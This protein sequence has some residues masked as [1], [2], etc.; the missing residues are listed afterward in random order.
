M[1]T[2]R[3]RGD[4]IT[5]GD[6]LTLSFGGSPASI[7][8]V[9]GEIAFLSGSTEHVRIDS[10]GRVGI[11]IDNPTEKVDVAG[12]VRV[13][14]TSPRVKFLETDISL[15]TWQLGLGGGNFLLYD[16]LEATIP[17]RVNQGAPENSLAILSNGNVGV[18]DSTPEEKLDVLGNIRAQ[19]NLVI[20]R[21]V[22]AD[23]WQPTGHLHLPYGYLGSN[24]SFNVDLLANGYRNNSGTWTSLGINGSDAAAGISIGTTTGDISFKGD[25]SKPSGSSQDPT[26]RMIIKGDGNVGIGIASP[27]EKLHVSGTGLFTST[28]TANGIVSSGN[29]IQMTDVSSKSKIRVWND[30]VF[31]IGMTSGLSFGGIGGDSATDYAMTFQMSNAPNRGFW[32]GDI[33][34]TNAQGAMA[35]TT[36]GKLTV[37]DSIRVGYGQ[38]DTTVPG[39]TYELDVNGTIK[40]TGITLS[41]ISGNTSGI[42]SSGGNGS[43]VYIDS[44]SAV[45]FRE[46]DGNADKITVNVNDTRLGIGV[47]PTEALHV[48]GNGLFTGTVTAPTFSGNLTGNASTA[49]LAGN[50]TGT[51]A[52][53]NGGTGQTSKTAAFDALSPLTTK[54]D[55]IVRNGSNNVRLPVGTNNYVLAADSTTANGVAWKSAASID[56][57]VNPL[58]TAGDIIYSSSGDNPERLPIGSLGQSLGVV[59]KDPASSSFT[60]TDLAFDST[61]ISSSSYQFAYSDNGNTFVDC[62][63]GNFPG[64]SLRLFTRGSGGSFPVVA[65]DSII[66]ETAPGDIVDNIYGISCSADGSTIAVLGSPFFGGGPYLMI[67]ENDGTSLVLETYFTLASTYTDVRATNDH[68][69]AVR[70]SSGEV[71]AYQKSGGLWAS[72]TTSGT[73]PSS[74]DSIYVTKNLSY[75]VTSSGGGYVVRVFSYNKTTG[76]YTEIAVLDPL[77]D[78][79]SFSPGDSIVSEDGTH[80]LIGDPSYETIYTGIVGGVH[81]YK[82]TPGSYTFIETITDSTLSNTNFGRYLGISNDN[83]I[84]AMSSVKIGTPEEYRLSI[85]VFNQVTSQYEILDRYLDTT[86]SLGKISAGNSFSQAIPFASDN[87]FI[88][89]DTYT[90]SAS[91]FSYRF[92]FSVISATVGLG[93]TSDFGAEDI[94]TAGSVTSSS[95]STDLVENNNSGF[96]D[97][98]ASSVRILDTVS[99]EKFRF[100]TSSGRLGIG[101]SSPFESLHVSGNGLFSGTVTVQSDERVKENISPITNALSLIEN[102]N[103]V[104]YNKIGKSEVE[105]GLIAQNVEQYL[106][107]VVRGDDLKS[108]AYGNVVAVLIEAIKELSKQV[109]ELK[110]GRNN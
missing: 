96:L 52:I 24:G 81:V 43:T 59:E 80:V 85:A 5:T 109:Q 53:A 107:E 48:S 42:Y 62:I 110:N 36:E 54:G 15:K 29:Y 83:S 60:K 82:G 44:D 86:D 37:A 35:L 67:Y 45:V 20:N 78:T 73:L 41:D 13:R 16:D 99:A 6:T 91:G 97:L 106:P 26:L 94:T 101:V 104:R 3:G 11:G 70:I 87:T 30:A 55:M 10:I 88:T 50:V 90:G 92:E 47:T 66:V 9:S 18:N 95:V 100:N 8:A 76:V 74:L 98:K 71:I 69:V 77:S 4:Y 72:V 32:W 46:T 31:A 25:A 64:A 27:T 56:T 58:T 1:P 19:G 105:I 23:F 63:E 7:K 84:I 103:G 22:P 38:S 49:T 89:S 40:T 28:L 75:F 14:G 17:F 39:A 57:F 34:H 21:L 61:G 12:D 68:I 102:I 65:T 93:Y 79:G 108:V 33:S 2:T 51:V